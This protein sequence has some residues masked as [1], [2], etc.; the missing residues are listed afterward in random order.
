[1]NPENNGGYEFDYYQWYKNGEPIEGENNTYIYLE[2][3]DLNSTDVYTVG[4]VRKGET[5][6]ILC[7]GLRLVVETPV[8]NIE[9]EK[10]GLASNIVSSGDC[11]ILLF[12][13]SYDE[14]NIKWWS[15]TGLLM[16]EE[17]DVKQGVI[18]TT[19]Q[20]PGVY[21]LEISMGEVRE[22]KK[23]IIK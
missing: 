2:G 19:P 6:E 5:E 4:L 7:C 22:I 3:E 1:L 15:A 20:I 10:I 9:K 14:C 13:E 18:T 16:R 11:V 12:D 21:L 23:V 17:R 8:D